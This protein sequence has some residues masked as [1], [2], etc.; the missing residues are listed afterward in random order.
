MSETQIKIYKKNADQTVE[1]IKQILDY[2]KNAQ[3]K[4]QLASSIKKLQTKIRTKT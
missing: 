2:N 1:I 4:F 3:K